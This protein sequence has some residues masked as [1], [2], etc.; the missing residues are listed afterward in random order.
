[1]KKTAKR[2]ASLLLGLCVAACAAMPAMAE[3]SAFPGITDEM[4]EASFW[5]ELQDDR[6]GVLATPEEIARINDAALSAEGSNMHDLKNVPAVFNGI[7]RC[8]GLKA[9]AEAD[10]AYYL[11][12]TYDDRGKIA[13]QE[14]YDKVVAN[15]KDRHAKREM[16]VRYGIVTERTELICLPT[17]KPI[18]DDMDDADFD[19]RALVGLKINEPVVIFTTS[20]DGKF[21]H[22]YNSCCSGWVDVNC[23]AVC[24]DRD[25]WLSAWDIP[26]E[27]RL[28]FYGDKMYTD[29][30]ITAPETSR[31][32]ITTGAS[33]ERIDADPGELVINRLPLHNYAAYLPVRCEDGSYRKQASLL[34]AREKLSEGYL[35]LTKANIAEVAFSSLGDAYGWGGSL[36]NEDCSSLVRSIYSCFGLDLPR[37]VNWQWAVD[38]PKLDLA[39]A[40]TE[41]KEAVLDEMPLG[42]ILNF[43]G[44][45]MLYLGEYEGEYYVLSTIGSVSSPWEEGKRQRVRSVTLNT[46]DMRRM[47]GKT[48]MRELK[49]VYIPWQLS[50]GEE[51]AIPS[52]SWYHDGVKY[53]IESGLMD[54]PDGYFRPDDVA[55][56]AEVIEALWR[57]SGSPDPE[58]SD[59]AFADIPEGA[60]Y[61]KAVSWGYEAGVING[62]SETEFSPDMSVT[63]EQLA[64][65]MMRCAGV[66]DEGGAMGLAGFEDSG[67]ISDYARTALLWAHIKGLIAGTSEST[68][69]PRSNLT[70]AQLATV[71]M[72]YN[73]MLEDEKEA[74][75]AAAQAEA[76][77][78]ESVESEGEGETAADTAAE[79][80]PADTAADTAGDTA[81]DAG[82]TETSESGDAN[83]E[84]AAAS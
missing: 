76:E 22:I 12:W 65:M 46:L 2:M 29:Y 16:P 9:S 58:S 10:T 82:P 34:N 59:A 73:D 66:P 84:A 37:N 5:S 35:P 77:A 25:E 14:Y 68:L 21:Y 61:A 47:N 70:R 43:P 20:A 18:L 55:S 81:A 4:T 44:H 62:T 31:R 38:F 42:T 52:L 50:S 1:M 8:E 75:E 69:G 54:A 57:L 39:N 26:D 51:S 45:Q 74:A 53:C 72:Q 56:R 49:Q 30:S 32:L 64:V 17:D 41:E 6:D 11:G 40:S 24:R 71:I 15:T 80:A 33:F 7:T 67:E 78:A 27:K 36:N 83:A 79:D 3:T 48:W 23:V 19:Y 13:S 60:S 28:V 63:R